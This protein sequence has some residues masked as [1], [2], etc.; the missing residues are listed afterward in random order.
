MRNMTDWA[1][2][3]AYDVMGELTFGKSFSCVESDEYRYMPVAITEGSK[4][5]YWVSKAERIL[6]GFDTGY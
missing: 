6:V 5:T 4:F 1:N 2:W 3:I